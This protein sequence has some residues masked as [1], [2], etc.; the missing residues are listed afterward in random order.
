MPPRGLNSNSAYML[1]MLYG[2]GQILISEDDNYCVLEFQMK[3]RRPTVNALRRD[4]INVV[5]VPQSV[6]PIEVAVFHEFQDLQRSFEHIL[7]VPITMRI[8]SGRQNG[9]WK[10]KTLKLT[11]ESISTTN[12]NLREL[13]DVDRIDNQTLQHI[14]SY[15]FDDNISN[16]LVLSFVQGFCDSCA[17]PPSEVSGYRGGQGEQRLQVE[18]N[19]RRWYIPIE[20]TKL[21]QGK[22]N[23][24]VA[25]INF[26]HPQT[27]GINSYRG[28]NHQFR[29]Y[30]RQINLDVFRLS[31]KREAFNDLYNRIIQTPET[32]DT[33]IYLPGTQQ[34]HFTVTR[35]E[36]SEYLIDPDL[37]DEIRGIRLDET[38][39]K[40]LQIFKLFDPEYCS[41]ISISEIE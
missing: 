12:R 15:F 17:L 39:Q 38:G 16:Q 9:D 5:N 41:N 33:S 7:G 40:N 3:Y 35:D 24:P 30:I 13:F 21:F 10:M 25:M 22:L 31:F 27:R 11:S 19:W 6:E 26:G 4:N 23:I 18:P 34:M 37:P 1:G 36:S 14:P 8:P 20:L 2:K 32:T 29:V 28:Q